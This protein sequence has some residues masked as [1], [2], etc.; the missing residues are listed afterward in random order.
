MCS[1]ESIPPSFALRINSLSHPLL[2]LICYQQPVQRPAPPP[3]CFL[4][5]HPT[6]TPSHQPRPDNDVLITRLLG[7]KIALCLIHMQRN[8]CCRLGPPHP[9]PTPPVVSVSAR[10]TLASCCGER[11]THRQVP[12]RSTGCRVWG[13]GFNQI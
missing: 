6:S 5:P 12:G 11:Q 7:W 9:P 3:L 2:H 4:S 8:I 1:S 10:L 13:K